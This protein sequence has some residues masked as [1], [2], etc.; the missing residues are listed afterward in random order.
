M[1][2]LAVDK[3]RIL[4]LHGTAIL[5]RFPLRNVRVVRFANQGHDWYA[6]EKRVC[7]NWRRENE[8]GPASYSVRR[9]FAKCGAAIE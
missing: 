4:G 5:S 8:K 6:D 7:L 9:S 1:Q 2:N 3:S